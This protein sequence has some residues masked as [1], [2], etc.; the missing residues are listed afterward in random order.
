VLTVADVAQLLKVSE[1][2]IR[3]AIE[4][5]ELVVHRLPAIRISEEDLAAY[6]QSR[7]SVPPERKQQRASVPRL[8][9]LKLS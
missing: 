5:G 2:K 8:K 1:S 3:Q 6:L 4:C 9:H 7:R